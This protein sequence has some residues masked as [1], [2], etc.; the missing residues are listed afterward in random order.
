MP[1]VG[2][3]IFTVMSALAIKHEAINLSQGFPDF[4][5]DTEL[6]DLVS[7]FMSEG[8]NQYSPMPG[9]PR[10]RE[11]LASKILML[12]DTNIDPDLNITITAGATQAIFTALGSVVNPGDEVI[13]FDP[14]YDCYA[15]GIRIFGGIP[16][17]VA[18]KAPDF[19]IDWQE[20]E[21]RISGQTVAIMINT[22][23]NP[24]GRLLDAD[25]MLTLQ[26]LAEKYDLAV[27]SDEVYEH[28]TFDGRP[29]ESVLRYPVLF[30]RSF[31]TFSFGKIFHNT[32]W[33]TGYCVAPN[34]LM[35]EFRKVHQFNVFCVN[36]PVQY[37]FAEYL[38]NAERYMALPK[39]F[40]KKRDYFVDLMK[41]S[42]FDL[43]PSEGSYF[44]LADY[45]DISD[46]DDMEFARWLTIEHGVAS[47]PLS[48]FYTAPPGDQRLV[49]FCFAKSEGM[50]E[51]AAARLKSVSAANA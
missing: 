4:D 24:V 30:E 51:E 26:A 7:R 43:Q 41:G 15:P 17:P 29:H 1:D 32:G 2:T 38:Q 10:L 34:S 25:D 5:C 39:F 31:A 40:E 36:T 22:P 9:Q 20:V 23:H 16:V 3:T 45:S 21:N 44:I 33:K 48:P 8:K 6:K 13:L 50:L 11:A 27:I 35:E 18:L 42:R 12:Y 46:M 37:A 19:R 28:I 14:S 47:I 49:R